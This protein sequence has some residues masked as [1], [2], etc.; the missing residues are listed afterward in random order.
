MATDKIITPEVFQ[1][2]RQEL[3]N[4]IAA[5]VQEAKA[6]RHALEMDTGRLEEM[7]ILWE[8]KFGDSAQGTVVHGI[9]QGQFVG[10][11]LT[12]AALHVLHL[13]GEE[14][15]NTEL[16]KAMKDGGTTTSSQ[17]PVNN[18]NSVL[19]EKPELFRRGPEGGWDLVNRVGDIE[20]D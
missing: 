4:E 14:L 18:L 12:E 13:H 8:R 7:L 16:W 15:P 17:R 10:M 19:L 11:T 20:L 2:V 1:Y 6:L 3:R 5:K 9:E